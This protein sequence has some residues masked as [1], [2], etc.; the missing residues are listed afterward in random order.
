MPAAPT[1]APTTPAKPT[2]TRVARAPPAA[3]AEPL[4]AKLATADEGYT[5]LHITP[6]DA[7]LLSVVV[8]ASARPDARNVSFHNLQ[9]FPEKRYGFV[10]LPTETAE[11]LR[12]KLNGA[13]LKGVKLRI[14][15]ARQTPQDNEAAAMAKDKKDGRKELTAEEQKLKDDARAARREKKRAEKER[16]KKGKLQSSHEEVVGVQ[17][18]PGRQVK[19]GWTVPDAPEEKK[20]GWTTKDKSKTKDKKEDKKKRTGERSEY[21]EGPECLFKTILPAN[22]APKKNNTNDGDELD[23]R[24]LKRKRKEEKKARE[25]VVHE[26]AH[27]QRIPTFLASASGGS[28]SANLEYVEGKGWVDESTGEVVQ[29]LKSTRP[30]AVTG[31]ITKEAQLA[32]RAKLDAAAAARAKAEKEAAQEEESETSD[33]GSDTSS[34]EDTSSD[35]EEDESEDEK[36]DEDKPLPSAEADEHQ[37]PSSPTRP[38]SSGSANLT[39][40]IPPPPSF[41]QT[42]STPAPKPKKE[43]HP[44]EALYKRAKPEGDKE[45]KKTTK[46]TTETA[47]DQ[48]FS[49]F[50]G[51]NNDDI[52]EEEDAMD[53]VA[54]ENAVADDADALQPPMTPFGRAEFEWRNVR[55]AAPTPDTAHPNRMSNFKWPTPGGYDEEDDDEEDEEED[56]DEKAGEKSGKPGEGDFQSWFWDNRGDL[57]RSWKRR[58]KTAAKDKRYRD[59]KARAERA[60]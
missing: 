44:L 42:P 57:N 12:R 48:P 19:R 5:R 11:R 56:N 20:S 37:Q 27:W 55:S 38:R 30:V 16:A 1:A 8:P 15:P 14:E 47:A 17:L 35:E 40:K 3:P 53:V 36:V 22:K 21:T 13:V 49:F 43:V 31:L 23:E 7:D 45:D 52:E 26:F 4:K 54:P 2:P 9:T 28:S 39:I 51:L 58:R 41:G 33:S 34:S 59:N 24:A 10:D 18:E 50:G 29:P 60:I 25:V 32:K 46:S 6:F